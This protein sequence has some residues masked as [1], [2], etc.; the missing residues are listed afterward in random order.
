MNEAGEP[1][2]KDEEA[3]QA[4]IDITGAEVITG[5]VQAISGQTGLTKD[6]EAEL[7]GNSSGQGDG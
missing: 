7:E 2:F 1:T 3:A 4:W 5:V 6:S